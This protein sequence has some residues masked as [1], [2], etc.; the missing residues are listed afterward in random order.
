M[1]NI[2]IG[3]PIVDYLNK[4]KNYPITKKVDIIKSLQH[5]KKP[6]TFK[7]KYEEIGLMLLSVCAEKELGINLNNLSEVI[8]R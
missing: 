5:P 8:K 3:Q 7:K 4:F 1:K 6:M 2:K